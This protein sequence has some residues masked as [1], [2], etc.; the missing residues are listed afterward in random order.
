MLTHIYGIQKDGTDESIC[1]AAMEMQISRTDL[2]TWGNRGLGVEEGGTNG[3]TSMETY[4]LP[5]VKQ[6]AS[7]NLMYDSG[8]SNWGSVTTQRGGNG[9]EV[10]ERFKMEGAYVN[11]WL[12]HVDEL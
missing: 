12:I 7:G 3:E 6:I 2:W 11:L 8:N 9:Q 1:R 4:T 5:Y 10:G